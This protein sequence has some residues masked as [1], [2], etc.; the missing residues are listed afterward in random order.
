LTL[1]EAPLQR[2]EQHPRFA[3]A[4]T[5]L[6][7]HS[8][9]DEVQTAEFIRKWSTRKRI[10]LPVVVGDDLELR[11]YEGETSLRKGAFNIL[12]PTGTL[13]TEYEELDLAIIPGVAFD[14]NG[15]RLGR[16]KGYYDRLLARLPATLYKI[17]ICFDFQ[18]LPN[19][20]TE[21][22]DHV[23]NEVI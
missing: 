23:M 18:K 10:I 22:H 1:S 14:P 8:L 15:N 5:L 16:G 19:I 7:Y 4:H 13:F 11:V 17:G 21:P 2:L 9:P 12:E 6:L 20:P 3:S